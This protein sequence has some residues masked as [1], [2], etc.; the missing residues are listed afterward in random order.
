ML[1]F[2]VAVLWFA[3]AAADPPRRIVSFNVC[4]DQLVVALADPSQ[5][6]A[7]SP[8]AADP[9]T[10]VVADKARAFPASAGA[11]N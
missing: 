3:A 7:L 11:R 9:M 2:A 1:A 8:Y 10:S 4:A 5:I 6:V